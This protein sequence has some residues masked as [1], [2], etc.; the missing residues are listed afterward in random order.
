MTTTEQ[1]EWHQPRVENQ[2]ENVTVYVGDQMVAPGA[3][4]TH[5]RIKWPDETKTSAPIGWRKRRAQVSDHGNTYWE[6]SDVPTIQVFHHGHA[7]TIDLADVPAVRLVAVPD[8]EILLT[9]ELVAVPEVEQLQRIMDAAGVRATGQPRR[10]VHVREGDD[11]DVVKRLTWLVKEWA[12]LRH[13]RVSIDEV[14]R[15]VQELCDRNSLKT[16]TPQDLDRLAG[17]VG[18][19]DDTEGG[20]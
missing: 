17:L 15:Q 1:T 2:W 4:W 13:V 9:I 20:R 12:T 3:E 18:P 10:N 5:A 19:T 14:R 16:A 8:G 11:A 6:T 7:V